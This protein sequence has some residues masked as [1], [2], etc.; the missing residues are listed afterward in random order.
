MTREPAPPVAPP[1]GSARCSAATSL[2]GEPKSASPVSHLGL[3]ASGDRDFLFFWELLSKISSARVE[4]CQERLYS[5]LKGE[6]R[7]KL[8]PLKTERSSTHRLHAVGARW[9]LQLLP[10]PCP[11]ARCRSLRM[12][13]AGREVWLQR[14][15]P[16]FWGRGSRRA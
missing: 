4:G 16:G 7:V 10:G 9:K 5:A 13:G 3:G 8:L 11:S 15:P 2:V 1:W 14:R 6:S 12:E